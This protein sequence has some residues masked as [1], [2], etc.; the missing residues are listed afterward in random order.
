[1]NTSTTPHTISTVR[2]LSPNIPDGGI[3]MNDRMVVKRDGTVVPFVFKKITRAIALAF[4]EVRN[5]T[6]ENSNRD[7]EDALYGLNP[8]DYLSAIKVVESV[9]QVLERHYREGKHPTIEQIQDAVEMSLAANR[10]WEIARA[11]AVYRLQHAEFRPAEYIDNGLSE[12]IQKSRYVRYRKDLRRREEWPEAIDRVRDMHLRR[13]ADIPLV[14]GLR[15]ALAHQDISLE[16]TLPFALPRTL[17][18]LI[19]NSFEAVKR[20]EVLP[21]MRSLQF[22][23]TAIEKKHARIYNCAFTYMDRVDAFREYFFLLLCGVGVGFSVQKCHISKLPVLAPSNPD[24][25]SSTYIVPDSI[26]GWAG[27]LDELMLAAIDG[28]KI[29]FDL[30]LIRPKGADLV[31][32]GGKAPG[33]EPLFDAIL[34]IRNVLANA[35]GRRLLSIEVYDILMYAAKAVLAGGVRRS[36]TICLFSADDELMANAKTGNWQ[37]ENLQRSASNNSAVIIRGKATREQFQ[38]LFEAQKQFGEPG[39]YFVDNEDQGCNPCVEIGLFPKATLNEADVRRLNEIVADRR[40]RNQDKALSRAEQPAYSVGQTL[41]GVQF[42]NLSTINAAKATD[43]ERFYSACVYAASIGTFQAGYTNLDYLSPVSQLI[44]EREA[45]IGVSVCGFLDQPE[46]LLNAQVLRKGA[47]IINAV[48]A[49][50][51]RAVGINPAARLTCVK[52]EGTAS[53][54]LNTSSGIGPHHARR[55]FRRVQAHVKDPVYN[56]FRNANPQMVESSIYDSTGN[57]DVITFPVEGPLNGIYREDLTALK[58][59]EYVRLVQMNW[60]QP[61]RRH[62]KYAK[63]LHHN[64]S[65]TIS[66]KPDEWRAVA[67]YIWD[68]R[69][70]FTG[71]A[72]LQDHGDKAYPQSPRE[73]VKSEDDLKRWNA[74]M[75]RPVDYKSLI[76]GDDMTA[77]I[78]ESACAGGSCEIPLVAK[79]V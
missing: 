40:R 73:T 11:Y 46:V 29:A 43:E 36:A 4:Y 75:P 49:I 56:H 42:C 9:C 32:S 50:I 26:E 27:A 57:T 25:P 8:D 74:L 44:T 72:L 21:S 67:D 60:V 45:L 51:A 62:E 66:V 76:E 37:D 77:L 14:E 52:P 41:T 16:D 18:Q 71:I 54:V 34:Q 35:A 47:R 17:H 48:N 79:A 61:G 6:R 28:R 13:Y 5:N 30:T 22:G 55:Y 7:N 53:L 64:V 1:M 3:Q 23:G 69:C 15:K 33:A 24:A 38:R 39:F 63:G 65:C 19:S 20:L 12:Y 31:T 2:S 78:Q 70:D 68:H 59:L 10:H 58:H